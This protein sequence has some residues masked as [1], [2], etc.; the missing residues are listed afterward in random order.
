MAEDPDT[1]NTN[2]AITWSLSGPDVGD[3]TIIGG[4]LT[5]RAS[6]N[7]EMPADAD[8]DNV[9]EVVVCGQRC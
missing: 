2:T 8:G 4:A 5:F 9:Y 6:P 3:F 7:Y 1:D